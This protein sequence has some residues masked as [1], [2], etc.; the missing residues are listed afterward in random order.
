[1]INN[2]FIVNSTA[3]CGRLTIFAL[4]KP[5]VNTYYN[6][7]TILE[8]FPKGMHVEVE[9]PPNYKN[10]FLDRVSSTDGNKD[11]VIFI[12]E[13]ISVTESLTQEPPSLIIDEDPI[14]PL[15]K[16]FI[17]EDSGWFRKKDDSGELASL[18]PE[19]LTSSRVERLVPEPNVEPGLSLLNQDRILSQIRELSVRN[20][21]YDLSIH[22][23]FLGNY[24][25]LHYTP[26]F[27]SLDF[28]SKPDGSGIFCRINYR[29]SYHPSLT[30][31][32]DRLNYDNNL[33]GSEEFHTSGEFLASFDFRYPFKRLRISVFG[34]DGSLIDSYD[35]MSFIH[36]I[37]FNMQ[38]LSKKV[39]Y[40]DANGKS[41][42]V[43][44]YVSESS[45]VKTKRERNNIR[46]L[47]D[48][49]PAFSYEKF[50]KS[51]DF[52]F[53]DGDKDN[54]EQNVRKA[55]ECV[56]RILSSARSVCYICDIFFNV[57][58]FSEFLLDF[59]SL[60]TTVRILTSKEN[61]K[62]EPKAKLAEIIKKSN[63]D[64]GHRIECRLLRGKAALHDRII[65][66]DRNIWM[67]GCSLNEFG[68]RAST[69]FRV[70][71]KYAGKIL[72]GV[73]NWWNNHDLS[74]NLL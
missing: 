16:S 44:K 14:I 22:Q 59:S 6:L 29:T 7:F 12:V 68:V 17:S 26:F 9:F 38:V 61:L 62:G 34:P 37:D 19:R 15:S 23:K 45:S 1:M 49:S 36:S 52:I 27:Q 20:L 63:E 54:E 43:D 72:N 30:F 25:V 11:K 69:L 66:A 35:N 18:I 64:I 3:Q 51:L 32:F 57:R 73:E 21:G 50:E 31:R 5:G 28:R 40:V 67:I 46:S 58:T 24:L 33:I 42:E 60:S 13:D 53:F 48:S 4:H 39:L 71:P 41:K 70:P 8:V 74:D 47:F 2:D 55:K 10:L 65:I 56:Q